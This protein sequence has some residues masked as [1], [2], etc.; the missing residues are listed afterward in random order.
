MG[1]KKIEINPLKIY[2]LSSRGMTQKDMAKQLGVSHV[3]L[4]HRI[5]EI[6]AEQGILLKYRAI[7]SLQ[8]TSLQARVLEAI[9]PEKIESASLLELLKAFKIL[10]DMELKITQEPFKLTGLVAYL[11]GIEKS[12]ST[13]DF[14]ISQKLKI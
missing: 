5:A 8:L 9:T 1:R 13:D 4:A 12:H 2:E 3:T 11:V 10:K 7:Q 14:N 6:Q